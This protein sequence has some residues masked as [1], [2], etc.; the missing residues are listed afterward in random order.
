MFTHYRTEGVLLQKKI[1]GEGDELLIFYTR[2]FGKVT[3]LGKSI[4]KGNSK[5]K[6]QTMLFSHVE[7]SFIQGKNYNTLTDAKT[8]NFFKKSRNIL[9]KLSLFYRI[10]ETIDFFIHGEEKD[11]KIFSFLLSCFKKI[12]H[13]RMGEKELKLFFCFFSFRLLYF[14]GYKVYIEKCVFCKKR[15]SSGYFNPKEGGLVCAKCFK[16]DPFGIYLQDTDILKC[17]FKNDFRKIFSQDSK[18]CMNILESYFNFLPQKS[19]S[20]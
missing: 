8:L 1:L 4:K 16:K 3:V 5:L 2:D 17:F 14:L 18:L 12:E 11:E 20:V 15:V 19:V 10:T 13:S 6:T 7:I 9:G